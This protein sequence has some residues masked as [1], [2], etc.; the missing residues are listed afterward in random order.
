MKK[1]LLKDTGKQ[2]LKT[3]KRFISILLMSLLGVGFFAGI[4][5]GSPDMK[6]TVDK[7]FD[8]YNF[9]DIEVVST[10]GLTDDD[11]NALEKIEGVE[12]VYSS[13]STDALLSTTDNTEVVVKVHQIDENINSLKLIDGYMAST[14]SECVVEKALLDE[15]ELKIG[16]Y[17]ELKE[18]DENLVTNRCRI[19]G[20]VESP[21]YISM[22][23]GTTSLSS[24]KISYYIY[25]PKS[26]I[27]SEIFTEIYISVKDARNLQTI[28]DEY[29]E[30]VA[31]VVNRIEGIKEERQTD[32][33]DNLI[34]DANKEL[35][36]ATKTL[37]K[38][39]KDAEEKILDA[40][41]EIKKG[42]QELLDGKKELNE[43]KEKANKQIADAE[44]EIR[45][46]YD[47]LNLAEIKLNE[48]LAKADANFAEA[49]NKKNELQTNLDQVIQGLEEIDTNIKTIKAKIK[50]YGSVLS[51]NELLVLNQTMIGLEQKKKELEENQ[52][53]IIATISLIDNEISNGKK[54]LDEAKAQIVEGYKKL[55]E[56]SSKLNEEKSKAN[57]EFA[58]AEKEIQ[59]A[60]K[61]ISDG[62]KE[63]EEKKKEFEEKILDAENKLIDAR[64]ELNDIKEATWYILDR[65]D[66]TGYNSYSQATENIAKLGDVFPIVFFVIATLI[67]L[68]TMTR[69]VEENRTQIGTFKALGYTNKQIAIKYIIY[70][71]CATTIGGI[72]GMFIGFY[73]LPR[74]IITM[75]Q[76]MY[77]SM[78]LI[79]EFNMKY[80]VIGLG[81]ML[82]C[83]LGAT[84]YTVKKEL[85]STPAELMRPKAPKAG[86]RVFLEHIGFIWKRLS[87]IQK[88]TLRNMFRYKKRFL[89]TVIG[90]TGCTGLIV[91]GFGLKDSISGIMEFQYNDVYNYDMMVTLKDTLTNE[92][93]I[94][95]EESLIQKEEID[96]GVGVYIESANLIKDDKKQELQIIVEKENN[97]LNNDFINLKDVETGEKV[98]LDNE[99]VF[100]TEKISQILDINVGD[101]ITLEDSEKQ[102]YKVKVGKIVENYIY[103]YIY[104]SDELYEKTYGKNENVNVLYL[105][106]SE[107]YDESKEHDLSK[108]ILN[109]SKT[110]TVIFTSD[111]KDAMDDTIRTM[112]FVVYILIVSAGILAFVVLY[113]LSNINI[114]ERIRELATIKVLGFYDKEVYNYITRE[115]ILLTVIGI[116]V[117]LLLGYVLTSFILGTC[118][119]EPLR[120]KKVV[121]PISYIYGI[122]ITVIFSYIVNIVTYFSLKKVDMIE[123]LKSVE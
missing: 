58:K 19:V 100:V 33:Y 29:D 87:F 120:F 115:I 81:T 69:M 2:I 5:A 64:E 122:I 6:K 118:E 3:Y 30:K 1:A 13:F 57:S 50:Q 91:A 92:E 44:N 61:E 119:P 40:E 121:E 82:A 46:G 86:K 123:S 97:S 41:N 110:S 39:K 62:E 96:N 27:D 23:R 17:I 34:S 109:S 105:R 47:E 83:I 68:T 22:E 67:S 103:H 54:Q 8:T 16:D 55:D 52:Q 78:D 12:N 31:E 70:A 113:N 48:E 35:D 49:E 112:N 56:A 79:I 72:I 42:K 89:M 32:R 7:Y 15:T 63:L 20:T 45:K 74:I 66:N 80:A 75:Y 108:E 111:S 104:M 94:S 43:E 102:T 24:G 10:L 9:Y 106:Y 93:I 18:D 59:D 107:N 51:Q 99:T 85:K 77:I 25:V 114:S 76:A 116:I 65:N 36:D 21:L 95:L 14:N 38:E 84:I 117:G 98:S 71:L 11:I 26:N 28:S 88:V 37:E 90:I 73:T 60:E 4:R 53:K 101:E